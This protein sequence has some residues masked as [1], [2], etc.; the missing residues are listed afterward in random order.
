MGRWWLAAWGRVR[1]RACQSGWRQWRLSRLGCQSVSRGGRWLAGT[2]SVRKK[3]GQ[4]VL[5]LRRKQSSCRRCRWESNK[6]RFWRW[7]SGSRSGESDRATHAG[8][9]GQPATDNFFVREEPGRGGG[10][11]GT[12]TLSPGRRL[13]WG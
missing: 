6:P 1:S 12:G 7:S 9:P 3:G 4:V 2:R 11:E 5:L 8:P 13:R 10:G